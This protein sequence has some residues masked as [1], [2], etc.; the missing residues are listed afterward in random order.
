MVKMSGNRLSEVT[1]SIGLKV[2]ASHSGLCRQARGNCWVLSQLPSYVVLIANPKDLNLDHTGTRVIASFGNC[3]PS[4]GIAF[5]RVRL[6]PEA[7]VQL[8]LHVDFR[9]Q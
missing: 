8:E 9:V 2:E 6:R 7:A 3:T 4:T 1:G 5:A